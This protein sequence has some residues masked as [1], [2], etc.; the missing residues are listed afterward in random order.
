MALTCIMAV[1][2]LTSCGSD[3]DSFKD[4]EAFKPTK[5]LGIT[6]WNTQGTNYEPGEKL[7]KN[8]PYEWL[9]ERTLVSV[10]NIYGNDGGQW[11]TKLSRLVMGDNMPEVVVCGSGQGVSHFSTLANQKQIWEFDVDMLKKYAPNVYKRIPEDVLKKFMKD[12]K[13]IG[14]PY[15]LPSNETTQPWMDKETLDYVKNN[16]QKNTSDENMAL[17][18][19]DDVLKKIYPNAKSWSDIQNLADQKNGPIGDDM[20]DIPINT[21]EEYINFM[22]KKLSS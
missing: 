6:I 14:I 5:N 19:R 12:G 13:L 15:Q 7:E 1:T 21:T 4:G 18:I 8:I 22:Y 16:V 10:D 20:F 11:D 17:W 3:T 9:K 2:A